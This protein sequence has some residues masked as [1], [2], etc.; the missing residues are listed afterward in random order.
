MKT[1]FALSSR[2]HF[3][4]VIR[5][6]VQIT[7]ISRHDGR[8]ARY[9]LD[10]TR[11]SRRSESSSRIRLRPFAPAEGLY[12]GVR[13]RFPSLDEPDVSRIGIPTHNATH[14][15][16]GTSRAQ[17]ELASPPGPALLFEESDRHT[18]SALEQ[19]ECGGAGP[20]GGVAP[21]Q[22]KENARR[23]GR[24][25]AAAPASS[26]SRPLTFSV[27]FSS[28]FRRRRRPNVT[29]SRTG[30]PRRRPAAPR[31]GLELVFRRGRGA[32]R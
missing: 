11:T 24:T 6:I 16:H 9:L 7:V 2:I 13:S 12:S 25:S 8:V 18:P 27:M 21:Q 29:K 31:A 5:C 28:L 3:A 26:C 15:L 19:C 30:G 23:V 14:M 10:G 20:P 4:L 17:G 1:T 22:D 32:G